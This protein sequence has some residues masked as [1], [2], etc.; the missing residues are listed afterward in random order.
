M[1]IMQLADLSRMVCVAEVYE[2]D[3]KEVSVGQPVIIRSPAF[4]GKFADGPAEE[5]SHRRSGGMRGRVARI[6]RLI[7]P[8]GLTNRN[9]LAPVDRSVVEVLIEIDHAAQ[10]TAEGDAPQARRPATPDPGR[11]GDDSAQAQAG[12]NVG[13]QVTVEFIPF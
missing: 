8:P 13:L 10:Q 12:K 7:A 6:G 9:P 5:Q 1:P 2:A 4:S 11:N 3:R